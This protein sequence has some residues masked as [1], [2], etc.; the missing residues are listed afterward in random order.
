MSPQA[1]IAEALTHGA[2]GALAPRLRFLETAARKGT[3]FEVR[4]RGAYVAVRIGACFPLR[5]AEARPLIADLLTAAEAELYEITTA[6]ALRL[7]QE[8][9]RWQQW[10]LAQRD[11]PCTD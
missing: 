7:T 2:A 9:R 3:L 5:V 1:I 8:E 11:L 6:A 10:A 4:R